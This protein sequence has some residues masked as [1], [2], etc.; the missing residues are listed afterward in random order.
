MNIVQIVKLILYN[1]LKG[2]REKFPNFE[3]VFIPVVV[4]TYTNSRDPDEMPFL[5]HFIWVYTDSLGGTNGV[6]R[7]A[8][9]CPN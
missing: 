6:Y 8:N 2:H 3:V 5:W 7:L 9:C 1:I 4:F